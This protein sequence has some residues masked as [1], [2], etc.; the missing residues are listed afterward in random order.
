MKPKIFTH[1]IYRLPTNKELEE[2]NKAKLS[3][4]EIYDGLSYTIV[5]RGM[6]FSKQKK[7][8]VD[9]INMLIKLYPNNKEYKEALK[10]ATK[11]SINESNKLVGG[12]ADNLTINDIANK[13]K[14]P[15]D[16]ITN[17]LKKG[18]DV[19]LEHTD[20][21]EKARE[22]AM[23]HLTELPDYYDRLEKMEKNA[24]KQLKS[25]RLEEDTKKHIKRLIR[26]YL[27]SPKKKRL[28]SESALN[29][30]TIINVDIQPE[31]SKFI[32]FNLNKWVEFIN[33]SYEN[34]KII[35]LYNGYETL[36][37]IGEN[38]YKIWLVDLGIDEEIVDKCLFYD[39][40]YAFFRYCMDNSIDEQDIVELVRFM[41]S[42][43]ITD[44]RDINKHMW[45]QF[46]KETGDSLNDIRGLL[47]NAGD[48]ISIPD[49]MDFL[50]NFSNIVLTGGGI[51]EC[52][53]EVEIALL[54]LGEPFN[55]LSQFTY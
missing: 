37:M 51:N 42:H 28:I 16:K 10:L 14:V 52:L 19:E 34:N 13:H 41:I 25:D 27:R 9:S 49:L 2:V 36:G 24:S 15:I 12:K 32:T 11:K 38:D 31:Y 46:M 22:I 55:I 43:N 33:S 48:M 39:K 29:G 18:L 7:L 8:I 21:K 5:G 30:K 50:K 45:N 3:A 4:K 26:E 20:D 1:T 54:A 40:G 23:D 53:K 35:F 44:S 17:Q 6:L 47:E